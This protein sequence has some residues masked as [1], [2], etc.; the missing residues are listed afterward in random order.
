MKRL[1]A[2]LFLLPLLLPVPAQA[3]SPKAME[4][5]FDKL[6]RQRYPDGGSGCAALVA[7]EGKILYHKAFGMAS[8]ELGVPM[9]PGQVFRI[10]SITKQFTA[11]AIL[12]LMEQGKLS[13]QD[14]L[15]KFIPDYPTQGQR[16]TVE[17]LLTHTSGIRS[18]TDMENFGDSITLD[19][20]P[21]R[22]IARF[23]NEP[24]D[25]PPGTEWNYSNS[26]YFLLGYIIEQVSGQTYEQYIE[27]NFFKPLGMKDS[28]YGSDTEIIPGRAAG[29]EWDGSGLI[30]APAMSMTQP[31][32]AG[33]IQSTVED[34]F[35]WHQALLAGKVIKRETLERAWTEYKLADGSGTHYG[36]G[37]SLG[38]LRGS[39]TVEHGG[40]INGFITESLYVPDADLF[41]AVFTNSTHGATSPQ[42]PA[43]KIAAYALGKPYEFR[44]LQLKP[45]QLADYQGVYENASGEQRILRA[46]GDSLASLRGGAVRRL[47]A[48]GKDQFYFDNSLT[49]LAFQR[50]AAGKIISVTSFERSGQQVWRKTG[51]AVPEMPQEQALSEGQLEAYVGRYEVA[52]S[53][54]LTITREGR[55]LFVQATGQQRLELF[56]ESESRF[57][58]KVVDAQVV[59]FRSDAGAVT[60]LILYQAGQELE[61]RRGE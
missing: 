42:Q 16:I 7:K 21:L 3:Q 47:R 51:Q 10:G 36:Y 39:R 5:A 44:E 60:H 61:G 33:S 37:W 2:F 19:V 58:L 53:F 15:P 26:G 14:E 18:Y 54:A 9:Q 11:V 23:R 1:H 52:P 34:L 38:D 28:R 55:R 24:L 59:F 50:D 56:A 6:L 45:E 48:Y 49:T 22:M 41:V 32:A 17:H 27:E 4:A 57:F 13:L 20:T 25:F 30:N 8:I 46:Q 35:L 40:G 43:A 29:Y 31:Y 12:Q